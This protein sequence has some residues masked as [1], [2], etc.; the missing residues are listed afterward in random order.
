VIGSA[1][2]RGNR[3]L[4]AILAVAAL[5]AGGTGAAAAN[6]WSADPEASHVEFVLHTF[7][8]D[9]HGTSAALE[10]TLDSASG[11]PLADGVVSVSVQAATLLT[12]NDRRDRKMREEHLE[13]GKFPL[14]E[15]RSTAP[16]RRSEAPAEGAAGTARLTVD[17]D[18]TIHGVTRK[19]SV[20]VEAL[21]AGG[22]WVMKGALVVKLTDFGVPDP[23]IA[24][25]KV[26]DDLDLGFEIRFKAR[27]R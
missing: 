22:A 20:L 13:V 5:L 4:R 7:W 6:S 26:K 1:A 27:D 16:P 8:H 24:L 17:G 25:N 2:W 14:L 11:D 10:A 3:S 21:A 12:G 15:F 9:V 23:S 18:L 19:V